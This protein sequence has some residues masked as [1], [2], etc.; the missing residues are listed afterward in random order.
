MVP[1]CNLLNTIS[2]VGDMYPQLLVQAVKD[3]KF[4]RYIED[5]LNF[6]VGT[7]REM[8]ESHRQMVHIVT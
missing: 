3:G 2:Q 5:N 8:S 4:V 1:Y 6:T 7:S